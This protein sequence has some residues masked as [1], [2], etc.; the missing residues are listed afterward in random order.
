MLNLP[1]SCHYSFGFLFV[2]W[3]EERN[4]YNTYL[5]KGKLFVCKKIVTSSIGY[6][7]SLLTFKKY[8]K[9]QCLLCV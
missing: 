4:I 3:K 9:S 7:A 2:L 1:M 5:P 6:D 8:C